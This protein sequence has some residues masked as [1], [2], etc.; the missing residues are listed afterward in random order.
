[1]EKCSPPPIPPHLH[2]V[3]LQVLPFLGVF[4]TLSARACSESRAYSPGRPGSLEPCINRAKGHF[5][6]TC[7]G[8]PFAS[9]Q[10]ILPT[11]DKGP[12][13]GTNNIFAHVRTAAVFSGHPPMLNLKPA[14][15]LW[16]GCPSP[17][18]RAVWHFL[19]S[20]TFALDLSYGTAFNS[21]LSSKTMWLHCST[22]CPL[23]KVQSQNFYYLS[24]IACSVLPIDI[25]LIPCQITHFTMRVGGLECCDCDWKDAGSNPGFGMM[26]S[27]NPPHHPICLGTVWSAFS[28]NKSTFFLD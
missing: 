21:L 2:A 11:P 25:L 12:T 20:V 7:I 6:W 9:V 16:I 23:F 8:C 5:S 26:V 19:P 13:S 4:G 28:K 22:G 24:L 15:A 18:G 27:L 1:M 14:R 17:G 3:H 10:S